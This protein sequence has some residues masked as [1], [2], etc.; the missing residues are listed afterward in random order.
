MR[1]G[2][3]PTNLLYV[4]IPLMPKATVY[5]ET[6]VVGYATSRP[7]RD[8]I[9]AF[10]QQTTRKWFEGRAPGYQLYVST[11][12]LREASSGDPAAVQERLALLDGIS[13]LGVAVEADLL[14]EELLRDGA[15]PRQ[16]AEDAMH[17]AI[18]AVNGIQYL[19]TWNCKH[20]ANAARRL[21]I[22]RVCSEAGYEPPVICTP[23]ELGDEDDE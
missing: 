14:A 7:S 18:C 21:D 23:E 3:L 2:L 17:I 12:V 9:T 11:V 1:G 20:I 8:A 10:K 16:A 13:Q 4:G 22:E 15:V 6:S 5:L 19:L